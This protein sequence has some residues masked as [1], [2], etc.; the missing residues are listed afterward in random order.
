MKKL[1]HTT[2]TGLERDAKIEDGKFYAWNECRGR[3]YRV[4][5]TT[6]KKVD[7]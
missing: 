2:R 4:A 7:A 3:W 6:I 1:L 5:K